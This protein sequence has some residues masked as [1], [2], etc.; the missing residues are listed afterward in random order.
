MSKFRKQEY[1]A[2]L[3][4]ELDEER[5]LTTYLKAQLS[6]ADSARRHAQEVGSQLVQEKRELQAQLIKEYER[7]LADGRK[8][9]SIM[10]R[11]Q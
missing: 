6:Y 1:E 7:G 3:R 11:P 5:K 8:S 9:M 2:K 10:G 4:L